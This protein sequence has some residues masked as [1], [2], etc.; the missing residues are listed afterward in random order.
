[1]SSATEVSK[2]FPYPESVMSDNIVRRAAEIVDMFDGYRDMVEMATDRARRRLR[3]LEF[4]GLLTA[5]F[6]TPIVVFLALYVNATN[7]ALFTPLAAAM[8]GIGAVVLVYTIVHGA[9]LREARERQYLEVLAYE[10]AQTQ[11]TDYLRG[12]AASIR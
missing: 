3:L 9:Y 1:M 5:F 4:A 12:P 8:A 11:C 7:G 2:R 10:Y 6:I